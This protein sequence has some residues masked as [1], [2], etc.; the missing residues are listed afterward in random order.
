MKLPESARHLP[1]CEG[2][3]PGDVVTVYISL[4]SDNHNQNA[5]HSV[6]N[7]KIVLAELESKFPFIKE[8]SLHSDGAGNY[9][10]NYNTLVMAQQ[11]RAEDKIRISE[12]CHSEPGHGG[13]C[14]DSAGAKL[15]ARVRARAFED[16]VDSVTAKVMV[17]YCRGFILNGLKGHMVLLVEHP[18]DGVEKEDSKPLKCGAMDILWKQYPGDGS[19]SAHKVYGVGVGHSYSEEDLKKYCTM[20]SEMQKE[21]RVGKGFEATGKET[22]VV[23][24]LGTMKAAERRSQKEEASKF[25]DA[26]MG[27]SKVLLSE[28]G[29]VGAKVSV[30]D[31]IAIQL[32]LTFERQREIAPPPGAL[33]EPIDGVT[34]LLKVLVDTGLYG[35]GSSW[36]AVVGNPAVMRRKAPPPLRQ[37][38]AAR[39]RSDDYVLS[40]GDK[41]MQALWMTRYLPIHNE[42]KNIKNVHKTLGYSG[43]VTKCATML[44]FEL[45]LTE[46]QMRRYVAVTRGFGEEADA[47]RA[48]KALKDAEEKA[49]AKKAQ[50]KAAEAKEE[51]GEVLKD[52][53][54]KT[55]AKKAQEKAAEAKEEEGE[56]EGVKRK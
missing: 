40:D 24:K 17:N 16:S 12:V 2:A 53:G 11:K 47:P 23:E 54:E 38:W 33:K 36:Q 34:R 43:L 28:N 19:V 21:G 10:K 30:E 51:E 27:R 22:V 9:R 48:L 44:G 1:H 45:G 5:S 18:E 46:N 49:E 37:G 6:R 25:V 3:E 42:D 7:M 15:A 4:V 20:T 8:V 50:E 39:N 41:A 14:C 52:A 35:A 56:Q 31:A 26:A 29:T 13:D 32:G 55:E